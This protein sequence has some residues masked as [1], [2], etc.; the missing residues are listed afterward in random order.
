MIL[1]K[2]N[3]DLAF[4]RTSKIEAGHPGKFVTEIKNLNTNFIEIKN[5]HTKFKQ[6]L[7]TL[8]SFLKVH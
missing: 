4:H 6:H 5:L 7:I 3:K 2:S 1:P 8:Y